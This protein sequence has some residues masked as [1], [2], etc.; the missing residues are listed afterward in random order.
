MK[1]RMERAIVVGGSSGIGAAIARR[2]AGDGATVAIVARRTA[3]LER[4]AQD[5]PERLRPYSHDVR[6]LETVPDLF[7][8]IERHLGG[9][10]TLVYAAGAMPRVAPNEYAFERDRASLIRPQ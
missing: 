2:L 8:R 4:L 5:A 3:N 7:E 6:A 10:D 1:P 9:V